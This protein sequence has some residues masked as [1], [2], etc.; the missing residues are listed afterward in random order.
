MWMQ[1]D[2]GKRGR[3]HVE[4]IK[5]DERFQQLTQ[6]AWAH[7]PRDRTMTIPPSPTNDFSRPRGHFDPPVSSCSSAVVP[8]RFSRSVS[9]ACSVFVS[10]RIVKSIS[11]L[12]IVK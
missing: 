1:A 3:I 4:Q 6:V 10:L 11:S 2:P 9:V 12:C 7:Q 8:S 5:E